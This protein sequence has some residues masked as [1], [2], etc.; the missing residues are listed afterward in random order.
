MASPEQQP[1]R[2]QT[3]LAY[4]LEQKIEDAFA[5]AEKLGAIAP[6]V[7][8][9]DLTDFQREDLLSRIEQYRADLRVSD[10]AKRQQEGQDGNAGGLQG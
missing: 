7:R 4:A 6:E 8:A 10:E 3:D 2:A 5:S 1:S 9:G